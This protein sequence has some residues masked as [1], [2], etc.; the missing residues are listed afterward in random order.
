LIYL[1][2]QFLRG[3]LDRDGLEAETERV[4]A[5][6]RTSEEPHHAAFLAS[7]ESTG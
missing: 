7:W 5:L 6:L 2:F 3:R 4:R 1:R